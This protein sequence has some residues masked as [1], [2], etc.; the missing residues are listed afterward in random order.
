MTATPSGDR[1]NHRPPPPGPTTSPEAGPV[2]APQGG[3]PS[4]PVADPPSGP[5]AGPGA[6]PSAVR[7]WR[8]LRTLVLEVADVRTR[9]TEE[10]GMSYFR[11]KALRHIATEGPLTLSALAAG[12]FADAPH[13]TLTVEYLVQ[14]GHVT[15]EPNPADRRSKLVEV[16]EQGARA[17]AVM[18]RVSDTPPPAL[19]GLSQA[20]LTT[21][22]RILDSALRTE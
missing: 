17:A 2:A 8:D 14:R 19:R 4:G 15:R 21:L 13:T 20:D 10:L 12:L 16:T 3:P 6:G 18:A 7:V 5:V 9:V 22:E 11:A 1:L